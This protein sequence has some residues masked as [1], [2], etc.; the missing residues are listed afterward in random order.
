MNDRCVVITGT[1]VP[2]VLI[3][4]YETMD[5]VVQRRE[6]RDVAVRR[7][8]Y[9]ET[10]SAYAIVLNAP[11]FFLEN[12]SYDFS[13][14]IE[15]QNLFQTTNITLVKF[16]ISQFTERGKGYQEFEMIDEFVKRI[17][18]R[19]RAFL[20]L[21]GRY[22]YRNIKS[23]TDTQT[24]GLLIDMYKKQRVAMTTIFFATFDFYEKHLM[25]INLEADDRQGAWIE[26]RLY[27]KLSGKI[28]R[29]RVQLFPIEPDLRDWPRS[30]EDPV[31]SA[32]TR[33]RQPVRNIER[34]ILRKLGINELYL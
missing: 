23:L 21:S 27:Q 22:Q 25:G 34:A 18:G 2:N 20:K 4:G 12:S 17:L 11:I 19:Y 5:V 30:G 8:R 29:E 33:L 32:I 28:F 16:P 1:I 26:R 3:H 24:D 7:S 6:Y 10:L 14:D 15:F 9:L 13:R 31:G